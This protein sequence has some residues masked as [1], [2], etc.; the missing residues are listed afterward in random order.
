MV[1]VFVINLHTFRSEKCF[2][3]LGWPMDPASDFFGDPTKTK[4]DIEVI[5]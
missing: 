5:D 3:Q 1:T 2:K 4:D